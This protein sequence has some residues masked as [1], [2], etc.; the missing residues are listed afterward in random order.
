MG[1]NIVSIVNIVN[2]EILKDLRAAF[3]RRR[4]EGEIQLQK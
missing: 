3:Y 1:A 4:E 2:F